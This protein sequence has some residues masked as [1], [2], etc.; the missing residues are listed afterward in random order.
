MTRQAVREGFEQFVGDAI[1]Q[2]G[3]EFDISGV[4]GG[5]GGGMVDKFLGQ[6]SNLHA[7]LVEPELETY[8]RQTTDQFDLI[9]E[10]VESGDPIEAY[11]EDILTTGPFSE[12]IRTDIPVEQRESVRERL[13]ER[14]QQLGTA[15]EPLLYSEQSEFW[16]AARNELSKPEAKDLVEEHF[17]FTGPL[18]EQRSAF[19]MTMT[20]DP[21]SVI[22][23][24]GDV[25][26]TSAMEID[27][28]DEAIRAMCHA[29]RNVIA[30]A[31]AEIDRRFE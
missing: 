16:Q 12:A 26:G 8:R 13:L 17:A 9:L 5:D 27:Y 2:T 25:L 14:H 1:E 6:S 18:R 31:L 28:T 7:T 20:F 23:G 19:A 11:R 3:Q 15:V 29:E 24:L 4:L 21:E 22:G 30:D 10:Y